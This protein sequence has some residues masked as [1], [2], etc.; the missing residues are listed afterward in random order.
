[1]KKGDLV[2]DFE[3]RSTCQLKKA[4]AYRYSNDP[5]TQ[6]ICASYCIGDGPIRRWLPLEGQPIPAALFTHI[7]ERRRVVTHGPFERIIWNNLARLRYDGGIFMT[8]E[9]TSDLMVRAFAVNMPG[10]LEQLAKVLG[11]PE[12]DMSGHGIMMRCSKPRKI[13]PDGKII[14]WDDPEIGR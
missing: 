4:G 13:L 3:T 7:F 12:K 10:K 6:I 8:R 11:I 14:W 2:L 5:T 9:Q 1:M